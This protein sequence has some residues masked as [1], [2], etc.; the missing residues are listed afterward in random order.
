M[1]TNDRAIDPEERLEE[2]EAIQDD[3]ERAEALAGIA[4]KLPETLFPWAIAIIRNSNP[5]RPRLRPIITLA[6]RLPP[7]YW[8]NWQTKSREAVMMKL[9]V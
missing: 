2:I 3:Y 7:I 8:A 6:P 4:P 1:T 5:G 9:W